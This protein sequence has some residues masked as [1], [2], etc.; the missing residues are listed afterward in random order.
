M[1]AGCQETRVLAL[2]AIG[3]RGPPVYMI[4][5]ENVCR[6]PGE[7]AGGPDTGDGSM[8]RRVPRDPIRARIET[9]AFP[10]IRDSLCQ[11]SPEYQEALEGRG[12][13][14]IL[15]EQDHDFVKKLI[16]TIWDSRENFPDHFSNQ[17]GAVVR[18]KT[19]PIA[20]CH[21]SYEEAVVETYLV[22]VFRRHLMRRH[23][24]WQDKEY[25]R[26]QEEDG[27]QKPGF[28][29]RFT[30][31]KR[32]EE[33]VNEQI[34]QI[35]PTMKPYLRHEWQFDLVPAYGRLSPWLVEAVGESI[36][37][38]RTEEQLQELAGYSPRDIQHA[39]Q[40]A[41]EHF[42]ALLANDVRA[43][44]ALRGQKEKEAG[45]LINDLIHVLGGKA[46]AVIGDRNAFSYAMQLR[47]RNVA[48]FKAVA[49]FLS[50]T[51]PEAIE[52]LRE[53]L[54]ARRMGMFLEIA[55]DNLGDKYDQ[56]FNNPADL[57]AVHVFLNKTKEISMSDHYENEEDEKRDFGNSFS[58]IC[59]SYV[60]DPQA[61]MSIKTMS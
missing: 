18:D 12:V 46:W 55:R 16:Q 3:I 14:Q 33:P 50:D 2:R 56:V 61:F 22:A 25:K 39:K 41:A 9:E 27:D 43:I 42:D 11:S 23:Q 17:D 47:F 34:T 1:L 8:A 48:D 21:K 36:M 19:E 57:K 53:A 7:R 6:R 32:E 35:F 15:A 31:K 26:R 28:F 40:I 10:D 37:S 52:I 30:K 60:R 29:A 49:P 24:E 51:C 45:R 20:P 13:E 44:G 38:V 58:V 59:R 4:D 5:D 54:S